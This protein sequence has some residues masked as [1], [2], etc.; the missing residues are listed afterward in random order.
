MNGEELDLTIGGAKEGLNVK[1]C[2]GTGCGYDVCKNG[3]TCTSIEGSTQNF[4]CQCVNV[5]EFHV[6]C[7]GHVIDLFT[8]FMHTILTEVVPDNLKACPRFV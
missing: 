3:G 5:S 4:S 2:D 6:S 1:D 8:N 7:I